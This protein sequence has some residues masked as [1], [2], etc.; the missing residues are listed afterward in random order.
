MKF[1]LINM[2]EGSPGVSRL[3]DSYSTSAREI[4]TAVWGKNMKTWYLAVP[5]MK[6]KP[7]FELCDSNSDKAGYQIQTIVRSAALKLHTTVQGAD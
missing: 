5:G 4:S 3:M 2:D 6:L 1:R 7:L